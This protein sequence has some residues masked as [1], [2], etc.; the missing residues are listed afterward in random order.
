[1][2]SCTGQPSFAPMSVASD[3]YAFSRAGP[4]SY[5]S[6]AK[7]MGLCGHAAAD[8]ACVLAA[9]EL[10]ALVAKPASASAP[11]ARGTATFFMDRSLRG[12]RS[13]HLAQARGSCQDTSHDV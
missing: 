6:T 13:A 2:I 5:G 9:A 11:M 7:R 12:R 3:A 4:V 8:L 10:S 1:M